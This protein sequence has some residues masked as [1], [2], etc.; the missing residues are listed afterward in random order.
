M[1]NNFD[2][3]INDVFKIAEEE[4]YKLHHPYVG[5]EHLYLALLKTSEELNNI[6]KKYNADYDNFK[7]NLIKVVGIAKKNLDIN[8]YTPLL[9]RIINNT[10]NEKK[11]NIDKKDLFMGIFDEGEGVAIRILMGMDVDIDELYNDVRGVYKKDA[12]KLE[13]GKLLNDNVSMDEKVV[14]RDLEIRHII[15]TLLRKK[16]NNPIL[17]GEAGVGKTAIVEELARRINKK[18]VPVCLKDSKI[19]M[20]EMGSLVAG[21]KYRGE[22]EEKLERIINYI[23]NN[24]YI[25]FIDEIHSMVNAGG[26]DG[27]I[28][29][30]NIL[31]PYLARGNVKLIG[32][33]TPLEY[34]KYILTDKALARRFEIIN[35][36]EPTKEETE[37]ILK[38]IKKEYEDYHNVNISSSNIKQIIR[39]ANI[40]SPNLKNPDKSI[41]LLDSVC[42]YVRMKNDQSIDLDNKYNSLLNIQ[43]LKN[44]SVEVNDFEQALEYKKQELLLE[45]ELIKKSFKHKYKINNKDIHM[46]LKE[47]IN[48]PFINNM[49]KRLLQ[50]VLGQ[51]KSVKEICNYLN[52]KLFKKAHICSMLFKGFP[53]VGKSTC[54]FEI[55]K[56]INPKGK[57]IVLDMKEYRSKDSIYKLIGY[58]DSNIPYEFEN[59][60]KNPFSIVFIKNIQYACKEIIGLFQKILNDEYIKDTMGNEIIFKNTLI[61]ISEDFTNQSNLG[62]INDNKETSYNYLEGIDKIV[63]FNN[64]T[65]E[66]IIKILNK[67]NIKYDKNDIKYYEKNGLK[68]LIKKIEV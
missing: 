68:S 18:E 31:K 11:D 4:R 61:I 51:E 67:N 43:K 56:I 60:L 21:T 22:F 40:Y 15:E 25:L 34:K 12:Y 14:G 7:S 39:M 23:E 47:K 45:E 59:I 3:E 52:Q 20:L 29:A 37:Y 41:D 64:L 63:L 33:T 9:K 35:V 53:G 58:P 5:S 28:S 44:K 48:I 49:E 50:T 16:K 55:N 13:Y 42:S 17:I 1:F 36:L 26:A 57:I 65:K 10:I 6:C 46:V 19:I 8:L 62:F 27:A 38:N 24:N 66:T 32:A 54:V 30:G 2:I